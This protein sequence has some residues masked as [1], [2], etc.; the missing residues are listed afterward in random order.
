M[1]ALYSNAFQGYQIPKSLKN[2]KK[3]KTYFYIR[4][5]II[6]RAINYPCTRGKMI[7][8][9]AFHPLID[10]NTIMKPIIINCL[11]ASNI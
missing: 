1:I 8:K 3:Q 2:I 10:A 6:N 11:Y 5:L 7:K 9:R 4:V